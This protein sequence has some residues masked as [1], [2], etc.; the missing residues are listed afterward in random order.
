MIKDACDVKK[1][2]WKL[3]SQ[4][5]LEKPWKHNS[6]DVLSS[7]K[8]RAARSDLGDLGDFIPR[9]WHHSNAT[10]HDAVGTPLGTIQALLGHASPEVTRQVYLHS[11]L[12]DQRRGRES[13]EAVFWTQMDSNCRGVQIRHFGKRLMLLK[14]NGRGE[15]I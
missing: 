6:P 10:L 9:P 12:E 3:T 14:M 11:V 7:S 8:F 1:K 5:W 15:R 4:L 2:E 13:R